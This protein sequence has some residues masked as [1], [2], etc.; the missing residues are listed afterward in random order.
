VEWAFVCGLRKLRFGPGFRTG[1]RTVE[2]KYFRL[3][4][5]W[6]ISLSL[7]PFLAENCMGFGLKMAGNGCSQR[8]G[9]QLFDPELLWCG[10]VAYEEENS[11]LFIKRIVG[12][13]CMTM[14]IFKVLKMARESSID[15]SCEILNSFQSVSKS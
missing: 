10:D 8:R 1:K 6:W 3:F 7:F 14:K 12:S 4:L 15:M 5:S 9:F 13:V 11:C 2:T